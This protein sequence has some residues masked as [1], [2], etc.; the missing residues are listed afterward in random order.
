MVKKFYI[1]TALIRG[2]GITVS[3]SITDFNIAKVSMRRKVMEQADKIIAL[4]DFPKFGLITMN[5]ICPIERSVF[6]Y[7]WEVLQQKFGQ[8][9]GKGVRV[10][11]TPEKDGMRE[12][13]I[14]FGTV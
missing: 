8:F 2:S 1:T 5:P 7:Y 12:G 6:W 13:S 10:L 4:Q 11:V 3:T 9:Q 14:W